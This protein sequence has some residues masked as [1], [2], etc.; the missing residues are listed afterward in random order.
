MRRKQTS[1]SLSYVMITRN[2][3]PFLR[4]AIGD[5]LANVRADEE[6]VV[7]DGASTDG[8]AEFLEGLYKQR[9][10]NYFISEPDRGEG[11]A[12]N[13][14]IFASR[15]KLIKFITDDDVFEYQ[16]IQKCKAFMIGHPEVDLLAT[17]GASTDWSSPTIFYDFG[18]EYTQDYLRWKRTGQPFAFC[19]LGLMCRRQSLPLIGL[20][21]TSFVRNDAEFSLRITAGPANLAWYTGGLF[22]RLL[23]P[24][25]I[26]VAKSEQFAEESKLLDLIYL[27]QSNDPSSRQFNLSALLTKL[28]ALLPKHRADQSTP[29]GNW[30]LP[31]ENA[32]DLCRSWLLRSKDK[33][34]LGSFLYKKKT[35]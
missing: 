1:C 35:T 9:K 33:R 10:L 34:A 5:L 32:W 28:M 3:L 27:S 6:V 11:H 20:F 15:G 4:R 8:S 29:E 12:W 18:K 17:N 23:N 26:S 31:P 19:G 24:G 14:T 13:K 21:N 25:S 16:R 30:Y 7:I 2:K 22:V